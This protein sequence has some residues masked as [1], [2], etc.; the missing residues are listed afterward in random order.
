M[1]SLM[2]AFM[3]VFLTQLGLSQAIAARGMPERSYSITQM[4][5]ELNSRLSTETAGMAAAQLVLMGRMGESVLIRAAGSRSD[6]A[7]EQ[8][9]WGLM[10]FEN[11]RDLLML[12]RLVQ[13]PIGAVV[14]QANH[15]I[16]TIVFSGPKGLSRIVRVAE[17][18]PA[19][20]RFMA[21]QML[22]WRE[23]PSILAAMK[24]LTRASDPRVRELAVAD[25]GRNLLKDPGCRDLLIRAFR[26][27]SS[28]VRKAALHAL[29][30][31]LLGRAIPEQCRLTQ[32]ADPGV[33]YAAVFSLRNVYAVRDR[34][35]I[36]PALK[37]VQAAMEDKD[38]R[39]AAE[40]ANAI[41]FW[42]DLDMIGALRRQVAQGSVSAGTLHKVLAQWT[43]LRARKAAVALSQMKHP[44]CRESGA[45]ALAAM[46][47]AMP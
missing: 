45:K 37:A 38:L 28:A 31:V 36:L 19:D 47:S 39:V 1:R 5:P 17:S 3:F 16:S 22:S 24:Q 46:D 20:A 34:D 29:W 9:A 15:S 21:A 12:I 2:S 40:A 27:R 25:I 4:F 18:G 8:A 11:E 35:L 13:D 7:R 23:A 41:V 32:D 10:F 33:R 30:F 6:L 42:K 44:K 43:S 26:D 14:D